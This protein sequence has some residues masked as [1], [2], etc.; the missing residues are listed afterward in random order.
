MLLDLKVK[1]WG[2]SYG[3]RLTKAVARQLELDQGDEVNIDLIKKSLTIEGFGMF[4]GA[5]PFERDKEDD[6]RKY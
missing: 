5:A 2:N 6:L 4:K 1:K 3:L